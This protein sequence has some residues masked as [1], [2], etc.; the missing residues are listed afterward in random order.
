MEKPF[1]EVFPGL[2]IETEL[3]ELLELVMV[4]KVAMTKDRSS[5]RIYIVSPR[6]I[7][8]K[9]IYKI[10]DGIAKQ[11]F[12]GR[13]LSVTIQEKYRLS[14]QYTPK[15]LYEIYKDSILLE[16]KRF[17]MLEY[18]MLKK[19]KTEFLEEDLLSL[20]VED[21]LVYRERSAEV[22]RILEKIFTE[23]CG[24]PAE[25]RFSYEEPAEVLPEDEELYIQ[26]DRSAGYETG[27]VWQ[28]MAAGQNAA[29]S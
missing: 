8:K 18:T 3:R 25:V 1:L 24:L 22:R 11:L 12:P 9:N 28:S 4:E 5:I 19:A 16:F 20:T 2:Q 14:A 13:P 10:E 29:G 27:A 15:T 17:G 26:A 7:H 23:R 6:L 21:N